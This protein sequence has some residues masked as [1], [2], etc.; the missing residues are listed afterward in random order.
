MMSVQRI[1]PASV[2]SAGDVMIT[3]WG[4]GFVNSSSLSCRI[5]QYLVQAT[6]LNESRITCTAPPSIPGLEVS[7]GVTVGNGVDSS[8]SQASLSYE[9]N[10][11]YFEPKSQ[12][13]LDQRDNWLYTVVS[14]NVH[15][16]SSVFPVSYTHLTL[17]TICSV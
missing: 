5:G 6:F 1:H 4:S 9:N 8:P 14:H 16:T 11:W 2:P 17:P 10:S 7:V 15:I 13:I 3:I 12:K